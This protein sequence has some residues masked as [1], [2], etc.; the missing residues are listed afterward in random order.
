MWKVRGLTGIK[1][2]D[3]VLSEKEVENCGNAPFRN[4]RAD[5]AD[6]RKMQ[7]LGELIRQR[8]PIEKCVYDTVCRPTKKKKNKKKKTTAPGLRRDN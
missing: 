6:H 4:R 7:R 1:R 8:F 3:V 2:I 5:N